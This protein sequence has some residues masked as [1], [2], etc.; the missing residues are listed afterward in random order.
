M[1]YKYRKLCE[2]KDSKLKSYEVLYKETVLFIKS[3]KDFT[4]KVLKFIVEVR[5]PI[6]TYIKS[7][8]EFK[9]SLS[10]ILPNSS[11]PEVVKNMCETTNRIG[12]GPMAS[13]AGTVSEYVGKK[14]LNFT[15]NFIIENGGDIFA[16]IEEPINVGIYAGENSPFTGKL[17]FNINL[18]N[19]PVGIC[20]SSGTVGHSLSFGKSDAVIIVSSSAIFSDAL[21]TATGNL[22]KVETEIEQAIEFAKQFNET[23]FVCI[24]KNK[25]ISFWSRT[26]K[27]QI[28]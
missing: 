2:N 10:P 13:V 17:S 14:L 4:K 25:T 27:I 21:A 11:M 18:L 16:Y 12:V 22:V 24:I 1:L 8:P 3:E 6:E 15:K 26:D 20:T 7:H 19:Q 28:L 23:L 5:K 9:T